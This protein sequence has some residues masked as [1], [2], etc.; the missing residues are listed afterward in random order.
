MGMQN[1]FLGRQNSFLGMQIS[2]MGMQIS[3]SG[4]KLYLI[5]L[6]YLI[7]LLTILKAKRKNPCK[8]FGKSY[9]EG[10]RIF[11]FFLS[12]PS[13]NP[14]KKLEMGKLT[15]LQ[16]ITIRRKETINN[17]DGKPITRSAIFYI[18]MNADIPSNHRM[19]ACER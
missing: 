18:S 12:K 4:I 2:K 6:I 11:L 16:R 14:Q 10:E 9:K 13:K 15:N 1:L 5:Y 7:D 8:D 19:I 3:F 17:E